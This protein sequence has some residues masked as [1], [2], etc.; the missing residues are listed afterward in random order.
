MTNQP[1][2]SRRRRALPDHKQHGKI[3]Q[4]PFLAGLAAT[5]STRAGPGETPLM[6][7][8]TWHDDILPELFWIALLYRRWPQ[9]TCEISTTLIG[10]AA[11]LVKAR[12]PLLLGFASQ[13]SK[14]PKR[15]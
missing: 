8:H 9:R 10:A 4:P 2:R 13:Y 14:I 7:S 6:R 15:L 5:S 11:R 3:L 12:P 1:R